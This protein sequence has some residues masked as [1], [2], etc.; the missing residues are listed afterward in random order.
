MAKAT[1]FMDSAVAGIRSL[2]I[3]NS[4]VSFVRV[5]RF[6]FIRDSLLGNFPRKALKE[7]LGIELGSLAAFTGLQFLSGTGLCYALQE[8]IVNYYHTPKAAMCKRLR[9][10]DKR[11]A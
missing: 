5:R 11:K 1:F 6:A 7:N 10:F 9:P 8:P 4:L 2:F 3:G